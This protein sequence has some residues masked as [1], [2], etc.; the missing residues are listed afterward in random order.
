[1]VTPTSDQAS[2]ASALRGT[3]FHGS[4]PLAISF[5]HSALSGTSTAFIQAN[6]NSYLPLLVEQLCAQ[7]GLE[8]MEGDGIWFD[9]Q[10]R[11]LRSLVLALSCRE[12]GIDG[13][14]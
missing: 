12:K 9:F 1:M 10:G 7:L 11:A 5:P 13:M 6:R 3:T 2:T 14:V 8:G 4:L